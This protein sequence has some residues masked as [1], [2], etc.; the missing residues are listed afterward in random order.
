MAVY[1]GVRKLFNPSCLDSYS[2]TGEDRIIQSLLFHHIGNQKGYYV[3]V[4]CHDPFDS[5]NTLRLY[6][7]GWRGLNIDANQYYIDRFRKYR[8][9]D[10]SICAAV[11]NTTR[12]AVFT[13]STSP[14]LSTLSPEFK[15]KRLNDSRIEREIPV[16]TV[17]LDHLFVTHQVPERFELLCIDVEGHDYEVLISFDI[18]RYRPRLIVIEMHGFELQNPDENQIVGYLNQNGYALTGYAIMNG[19][20]IDICDK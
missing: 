17:T 4:G 7:S 14:L 15:A 10:V 18:R 2:F 11:S 6:R 20:F 9:R 19:Y 5:S 12:N 13:V 1:H 16:Q 3:D 8:P